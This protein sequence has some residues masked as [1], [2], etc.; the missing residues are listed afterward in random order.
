M[1]YRTDES[2][3]RRK[4]TPS[5][6]R[7]LHDHP[8]G[9]AKAYWTAPAATTLGG[10]HMRPRVIAAASFAGFVAGMFIAGYGAMDAKVS[11]TTCMPGAS[12]GPVIQY[13]VG[14]RVKVE[15]LL[16]EEDKERHQPTLSRT[17]TRYGIRGTDLGNSFEHDGRV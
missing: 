8:A 3:R 17:E 1:S 11:G 2:P 10:L 4:T 13:V 15:Q 14:S 9:K 12:A 5:E 6:L 7:P 16:G